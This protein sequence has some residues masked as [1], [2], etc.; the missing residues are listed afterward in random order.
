MWT[1]AELEKYTREFVLW[2]LDGVDGLDVEDWWDEDHDNAPFLEEN[3]LR[4]LEHIRTGKIIIK[5]GR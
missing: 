3:F 1:D 4:I 5:H 2:Q